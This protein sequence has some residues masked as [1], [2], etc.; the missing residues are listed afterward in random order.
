MWRDALFHTF[1][2]TEQKDVLFHKIVYECL[3][4]RFHSYWLQLDHQLVEE[5]LKDVCREMSEMDADVLLEE[6]KL[7][8]STFLWK[9]R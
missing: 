4:G 8:L 5:S 9:E 1:L 2:K 3:M 6:M 7:P